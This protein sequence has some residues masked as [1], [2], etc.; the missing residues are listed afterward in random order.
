MTTEKV[1]RRIYFYR[2]DTGTDQHGRPN[3]FD[4]IDVAKRLRQV[5]PPPSHY[6]QFG[7]GVEVA[8]WVDRISPPQIR[9][10]LV[11][12]N[13]LPEVEDAGAVKP[14]NL[15]Q[16][17]GLSEKT[18]IVFFPDRIV[19]I[20]FNFYGPRI[21]SLRKYLKEKLELNVW[22][23]RLLR[24]DALEQLQEM[25]GATSVIIKVEPGYAAEV[26]KRSSTIGNALA[27]MSDIKNTQAVEVRISARRGT[28][29][30]GL[31]DDVKRIAGL[32]TL[33]EH[34]AKFV[35]KGRSEFERRAREVDVLSDGLVFEEAVL[36]QTERGRAVLS[37]DMF[38]AIRKGYDTLQAEIAVAA[39]AQY[40]DDNA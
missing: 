39:E 25:D 20:D 5:I 10:A 27:A 34:A 14:L 29:L 1:K 38:K 22:F 7:T 6:A 30:R 33:P 15:A 13:N 18:H 26:A 40:P 19:G 16:Q 11:R 31:L 28:F 21:S 24:H 3:P 17:E 9:L 35:V 2:V 32:D 23:K 8:G 4:E 36:R 12:R 37:T